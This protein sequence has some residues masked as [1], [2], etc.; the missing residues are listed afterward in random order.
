MVQLYGMMANNKRSWVS[1]DFVKQKYVWKTDQLL[2][3]KDVPYVGNLWR[4]MEL[5][6]WF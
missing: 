3:W 6:S 5:K 1:V 4:V 2:F